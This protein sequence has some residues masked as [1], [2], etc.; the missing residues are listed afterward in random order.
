MTPSCSSTW[1]L[2]NPPSNEQQTTFSGQGTAYSGAVTDGTGF[3]CSFRFLNP[4]ARTN[5]VAINAAQWQNGQV[6]GQCVKV[7]CVDPQCKTQTPVKLYAVDKCP[8]CAE[9]DLDM[10]IPAYKAVTGLWPNRLKIEWEWT[11]C[12][13]DMTGN[14]HWDP[15]DGSNAQWQAF[16]ISN[17]AQSLATVKLN[18]VELQRQTFNFWVHSSSLGSAPYNLT[19]ISQNGDTLTKSVSNVLKSQDLG[20][21]F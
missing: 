15:K 7:W 10:S 11:D 9:G 16:Y 17:P 19:F 5:F 13:G 12:G 2:Q 14:I 18:G 8:E 3:A 1:L 20:I 6:C 21:N 4:W